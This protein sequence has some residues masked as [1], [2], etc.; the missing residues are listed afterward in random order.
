MILRISHSKVPIYFRTGPN[1][2]HPT[3]NTQHPISAETRGFGCSMLD[4]GCWMFSLFGSGVQG[5]KSPFR[6]ILSP[7][8]REK[9]PPRYDQLW[10]LAGTLSSGALPLN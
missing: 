5:A 10:R 2:Q 6:G 1:I 8:E 9:Y 3:S 4:V 7:E